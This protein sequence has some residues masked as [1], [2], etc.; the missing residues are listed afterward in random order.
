[1]SKSQP[2]LRSGR[3]TGSGE[4][5]ALLISLAELT[6]TH[7]YEDIAAEQ[8]ARGAGLGPEAFERHFESKQ[9]CLATAYDALTEQAFA[10]ASLAYV[11]TSGSWAMAVYETLR[12]LFDFL[13]GAPAFTNLYAIETVR[14]ERA[15]AQARDR[16]LTRLMEFLEPGFSEVDEEVMPP[17]IAAEA[18][19]GGL[20]ELIRLHVAR[21]RTDGLPDALPV[22]TVVALS[23][24]VGLEQ[25]ERI[26]RGDQESRR[27]G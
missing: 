9:S 15:I 13:A 8:I 25:A 26:A 17:R 10:S 1:M 18:I 12:A 24:F 7:R 2:I 6:L 4:R 16:A 20:F 27:S 22:A 14:S 19:A 5:D 3:F 23:P 11:N 21:G